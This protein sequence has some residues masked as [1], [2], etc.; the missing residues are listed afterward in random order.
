MTDFLRHLFTGRDGVTFDL[1]RVLWIKLATAF[2]AL[3]AWHVLHGGAFDPMAWAGGAA[4]ILAGGG[5]ALGLKAS[6][7][8][9]DK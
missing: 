9:G 2:V 6:T 1:G 5:A 8:P 3:S 7:E 4:A